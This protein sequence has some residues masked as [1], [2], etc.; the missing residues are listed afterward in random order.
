MVL[1]GAVVEALHDGIDT[2]LPI[3]AGDGREALETVAA[4]GLDRD[5][6]EDRFLFVRRS[7]ADVVPSTLTHTRVSGASAPQAP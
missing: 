1:I 3:R 7:S 6:G 2:I 4:G 5:V